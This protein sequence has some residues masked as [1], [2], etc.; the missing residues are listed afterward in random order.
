M[1]HIWPFMQL[2]EPD[3]V[4]CLCLWWGI[5]RIISRMKRSLKSYERS[6]DSAPQLADTHPPTCSVAR[7]LFAISDI[8]K[9]DKLEEKSVPIR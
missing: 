7:L 5:N 3:H 4:M 8:H 9:R 6:S 2:P 1:Y